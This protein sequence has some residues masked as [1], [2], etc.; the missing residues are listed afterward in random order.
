SPDHDPELRLVV[1]LLGDRWE[2]DRLAGPD[3]GVVELGEQQRA[4]RQVLA[5]LPGVLL[6]VEAD[7]DDLPRLD[8]RQQLDVGQKDGTAGRR[9]R[10]DVVPTR[11]D[12]V[13]LDHAG[14][15]SA[16][17]AVPDQ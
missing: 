6:V 11:A 16:A 8:R 4:R 5:R 7:A 3:D 2:S 1:D 13:A 14:L 17:L 15:R 12:G 10:E 9:R